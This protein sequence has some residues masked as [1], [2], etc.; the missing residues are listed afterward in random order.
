MNDLQAPPSGVKP[1]TAPS[2]SVGPW[3]ITGSVANTAEGGSA[4]ERVDWEHEPP[5]PAKA[6]KIFRERVRWELRAKLRRISVNTRTR[7]CGCRCISEQG[8]AI[9]VRRLADGVK[10][11][12]LR[13]LRC[14]HVWTCP[15]CASEIRAKR[16]D[17]VIRAV[18]AGT[19]RPW[20]MITLTIRHHVGAPL[21]K[22]LDGLMKSW[23]KTRQIGTIQRLWKGHV[24]ASIRA[25]EITH[26]ANGWH[27][28]LH[29]LI[30]SDG[31][32]R[33]DRDA[34]MAAWRRTVVSILGVEHIPDAEIGVKWSP[35]MRSAHDA[36]YLSKL[37]LEMSWGEKRAR[38]KRSRGPWTIARDA[39]GGDA[40][41]VMLWKEYED[42]T[43]GRRALE[44]DDRAAA[45]AKLGAL[46]E[47]AE[48]LAK[49]K[50]DGVEVVDGL[51]KAG[52][53][54]LIPP[55]MDLVVL[56]VESHAVWLLRQGERRLPGI[57]WHVLRAIEDRPEV[58]QQT[59]DHW[60]RWA[61]RAYA[62]FCTGAA[63]A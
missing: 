30:Q 23:R 42:A 26:G 3:S 40:Q 17:Q 62:E 47:G 7:G 2:R 22:L 27:P 16:R 41:S 35:A 43:K 49:K 58:A 18:K 19:E 50:I 36:G 55:G 46:L 63:A 5:N 8:A 45:L 20:R 57:M 38:G 54:P 48:A 53:L 4:A 39:A 59:L 6:K 28:H 31:W 37:G 14:G 12:W 25:V 11:R 9:E 61:A 51:A 15:C 29:V 33:D 34:L 21:K 56:D 44:L 24:K 32:D 1:I 10:A 13:L 60:V 52:P